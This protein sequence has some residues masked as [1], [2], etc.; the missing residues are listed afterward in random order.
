V[1]SSF[2]FVFDLLKTYDF[3]TANSNLPH[4]EKWVWKKSIYDTGALSPEQ[5][6]FAA[7]TGFIA[8][9]KA[10]LSPQEIREKAAAAVP[11]AE[12]MNLYCFEQPLINFLIV[13][14]GKRYTSLRWLADEEKMPG[15]KVERWAGD[16][17]GRLIGEGTIEFKDSENE[18]LFLHWAG[19]WQIYP[20]EK[21]LNGL[22]KK[23][24]INRQN[25]AVVNPRM[26]YRPL[27]KYYRYL[28]A[29]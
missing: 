22:L 25:G 8:S 24:G 1:L 9:K 29:K 5:I 7:N 3:V 23:I 28:R 20:W 16:K 13:T 18:L 27:W 10:V 15:I 11:L 2:D 12:H 17:R 4:T 21:K 26:P 14:S 6:K 19:E